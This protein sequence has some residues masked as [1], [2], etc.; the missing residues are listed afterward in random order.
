MTLKQHCWWIST[1]EIIAKEGK[2]H[3]GRRPCPAGVQSPYCTHSW[4]NHLCCCTC[5]DK[6]LMAGCTHPRLHK[7]KALP[8]NS[9]IGTKNHTRNTIVCMFVIF[10]FAPHCLGNCS[11]VFE[12]NWKVESRDLILRSDTRELL[13]NGHILKPRGWRAAG[14]RWHTFWAKRKRTLQSQAQGMSRIVC[15][16]LTM[17]GSTQQAAEIAVQTRFDYVQ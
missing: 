9:I 7:H 10:S 4:M 14:Q 6:G 13:S 15:Q 8:A 2:A 11:G 1:S 16:K 12:G 3:L 17:I 5:P